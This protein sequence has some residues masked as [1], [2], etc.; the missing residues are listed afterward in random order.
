MARATADQKPSQLSSSLH[1]RV[2]VTMKDSDSGGHSNARIRV[3]MIIARSNNNRDSL[4]NHHRS[5]C[6]AASNA[7]LVIREHFRARNLRK[8]IRDFVRK[9]TRT[10]LLT[11]VVLHMR[12]H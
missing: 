10:T 9:R 6:T 8:R 11:Q 1:P 2:F 4:N 5:I 3:R 7:L 12:K